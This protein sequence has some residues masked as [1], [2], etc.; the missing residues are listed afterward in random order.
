MSHG[1][2]DHPAVIA[3]SSQLVGNDVLPW[4]TR[5]GDLP[6]ERL[7]AWLA[8]LAAPIASH[9]HSDRD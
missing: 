8:S 7:D 1:S 9:Q 2:L 6:V 5:I 4:A 3:P